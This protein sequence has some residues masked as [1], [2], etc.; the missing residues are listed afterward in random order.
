MARI[1][2]K[3]ATIRLLDGYSDDA[4]VNNGA[5]YPAGTTTMTIDA[6]PAAALPIGVAF[7]VVGDNVIHVVTARS[8]GPPNT[9]ITFTPALAN[10]VLDNAVI[11]FIGRSL[12]VNIGEGNLTYSEKKNMDYKLNRGVLDSVVEG[13]QAPMEV[14][15]DFIWEFLTAISG[16]DTP[17]IEDALKQRGPASTW[18]SSA[19]EDPCAPYALDIMVE[20]IPNCEDIAPEVI[21]LHD[22][23]YESLDHDFTAASVAAQ[24][25]CNSVEATVT[26]SEL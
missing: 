5:G 2:L 12:E 21:T 1:D 3:N 16:A 20:Y 24:G 8:G 23:R 13:D 14:S 4:A 6:A 11:T 15:M 10:A 7:T 22:F 18:I 26:R 17:T 19:T 9:S 25:K